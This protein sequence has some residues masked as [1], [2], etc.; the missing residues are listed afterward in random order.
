M[1]KMQGWPWYLGHKGISD[2]LGKLEVS[3]AE[4]LVDHVYQE[5]FRLILERLAATHN[6]MVT[7]QHQP[8]LHH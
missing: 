3:F 1:D 8:W 6:V 4:H 5:V 2:D 7:R